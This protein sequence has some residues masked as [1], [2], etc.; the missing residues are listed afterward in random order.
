MEERQILLQNLFI[1]KWLIDKEVSTGLVKSVSWGFLQCIKEFLNEP[2][3]GLDGKAK[4]MLL[5]VDAQVPRSCLPWPVGAERGHV[6]RTSMGLNWCSSLAAK[7][8]AGS[9]NI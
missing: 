7:G 5:C 1:W 6:T 3:L 4:V 9:Q 8:K 2:S